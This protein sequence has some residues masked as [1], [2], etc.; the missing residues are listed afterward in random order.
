MDTDKNGKISKQTWMKFMEIEF[1]KL[2]KNKTGQ[3]DQKE[4]LQSRVL[5]KHVRHSDLGK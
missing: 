5:V 3:L 4:L 2:D 1:D